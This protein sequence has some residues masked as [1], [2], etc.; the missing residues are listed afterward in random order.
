MRFADEFA[1]LG[2]ITTL[3]RRVRISDSL[4]LGENVP[5]AAIVAVV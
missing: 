4:V 2:D 3:E 5:A 1:E